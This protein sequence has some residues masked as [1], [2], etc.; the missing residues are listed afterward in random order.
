[1][2]ADSLLVIICYLGQVT[3]T[4]TWCVI[5]GFS[6]LRVLI[7][8]QYICINMVYVYKSCDTLLS[9]P[10]RCHNFYIHSQSSLSCTSN[11]SRWHSFISLLFISTYT[12]QHVDLSIVTLYRN[13]RAHNSQFKLCYANGTETRQLFFICWQWQRLPKSCLPYFKWNSCWCLI[14]VFYV[15]CSTC[16][17][18]W[19]V[20]THANKWDDKKWRKPKTDSGA[21][22]KVKH[23]LLTS[24][25]VL[26]IHA[27]TSLLHM[28][29][30]SMQPNRK[31]HQY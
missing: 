7:W 9:A 17:V 23:K 10:P 19:S 18:E 24:V 16:W 8:L 22:S 26:T 20:V 25:V 6:I 5:V 1:M 15:S 11:V 29:Q 2:Q 21:F 4:I 13:S 27:L 14:C 12:M 31:I 3:I 30:W 28:L